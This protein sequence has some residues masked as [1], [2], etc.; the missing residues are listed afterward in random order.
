MPIEIANHFEKDDL[1]SLARTSKEFGQVAQ[2]ILHHRIRLRQRRGMDGTLVVSGI[3][4]LLWTLV[5]RQDLGAKMLRLTIWPSH[6]TIVKTRIAGQALAHISS[7]CHLT[8]SD[9]ILAIIEEARFAGV[10]LL[11]LPSL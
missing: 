10:L 6:A 3:V 9:Y 2:D 5:R 11:I 7:S 1:I 4:Q 8:T